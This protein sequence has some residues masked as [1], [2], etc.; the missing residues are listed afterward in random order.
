MAEQKCTDEE[1]V[2]LW[3][4][5]GGATAVAKFLNMTVR[6]TQARRSRLEKKGIHLEARN[7]QGRTVHFNRQEVENK[8][9]ARLE[10][11]RVNARRG[12]ALDDATVFVFSDAHFY[13]QDY[14]TAFRALIYFIKE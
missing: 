6:A 4:E 8:V 5:L 14:T 3:N 1:F 7:L 13:P 2:R 11:T 10:E 9:R 12:I